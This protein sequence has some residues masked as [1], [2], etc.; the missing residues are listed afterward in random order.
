[1]GLMVWKIGGKKDTNNQ[2]RTLSMKEDCTGKRKNSADDLLVRLIALTKGLSVQ[3]LQQFKL[4]R[5][6]KR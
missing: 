4:R 5:R 6:T 1:M 2:G 3:V